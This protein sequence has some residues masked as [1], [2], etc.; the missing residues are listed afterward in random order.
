MKVIKRPKIP[1]IREI[2]SGNVFK[3]EKRKFG[4]GIR[5]VMVHY[6]KNK[7]AFFFLMWTTFFFKVFIEFVTVLL[8]FYVLVFGSKA[9][10]I[11]A[12]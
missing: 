5:E 11:V 4:L 3:K 7:E 1:V 10:G 6:S 2:S 12:I 9:C 8:L